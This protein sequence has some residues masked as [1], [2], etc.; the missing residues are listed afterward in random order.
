MYKGYKFFP[1]P[2]NK[3]LI[4]ICKYISLSTSGIPIDIEFKSLYW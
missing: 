2:K 4:L 3:I 1:H